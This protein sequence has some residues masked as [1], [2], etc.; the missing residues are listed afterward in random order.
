MRSG[1]G[2]GGGEGG[3]IAGGSGGG[4]LGACGIVGGVGE[5]ATKGGDG[6]SHLTLDA[7]KVL[8][9]GDNMP[10]VTSTQKSR[11]AVGLRIC[12]RHRIGDRLST[13]FARREI[14][15][16]A[17]DVNVEL[18]GEHALWWRWRWRC[19]W[20]PIGRCWRRWSGG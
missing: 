5:G 4:G 10:C 17:H 14:D 13:G 1:G 8:A 16:R 12:S 15:S 7:I 6:G 3:D 18:G 11:Q 9:K 19:L 2:E 20:R